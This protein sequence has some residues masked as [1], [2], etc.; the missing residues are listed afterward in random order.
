MANKCIVSPNFIL[1]A[2]IITD[3][4]VAGTSCVGLASGASYKGIVNTGGVVNA[5]AMAY[6]GIAGYRIIEAG[7]ITDKCVVI[8]RSIIVAGIVADEG[9][10]ISFC[11]VLT[12]SMPCSPAEKGIAVAG[13]SIRDIGSGN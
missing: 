5:R 13:G 12:G 10:E 4:G 3:E 6:K 9:I 8:T 11:P 7:L 1:L 2:G